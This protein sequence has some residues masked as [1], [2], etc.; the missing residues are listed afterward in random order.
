MLVCIVDG[1]CEHKHNRNES[2]VY[3]DADADDVEAA[4]DDDHT[5]VYLK[6]GLVIALAFL[7]F[8]LTTIK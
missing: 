6:C 7:G 4:T 1:L 2:C 8:N 3:V 5:T